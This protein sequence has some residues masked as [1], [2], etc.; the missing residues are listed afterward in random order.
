MATDNRPFLDKDKLR[1]FRI[2]R[3]AR[4][5]KNRSSKDILRIGHCNNRNKIWR[6]LSGAVLLDM[7]KSGSFA[8]RVEIDR[9]RKRAEKRGKSATC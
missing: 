8:A 7:M 9:R 3:G 2:V 6:S 1:T 5:L 4:K